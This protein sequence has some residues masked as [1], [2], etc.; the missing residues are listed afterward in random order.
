MSDFF[1]QGVLHPLVMPAHL[2]LLIALGLL[3]GQQSGRAV[4]AS[5]VILLLSLI[6]A[7]MATLQLRLRL[8]LEIALLLSAMIAGGLVALRLKLPIW[9]VLLLALVAGALV[10]LDSS[11]P[12]I[13]GLR[14]NKVHVLLA[15]TTLSAVSVSL[16]CG[17]FALMV[18]NLLEGIVLRVLGAWITAGALLVLALY[19]VRGNLI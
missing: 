10:G 1:L 8:E 3:A 14:G 12:R 2:I 5:C 9:P 11:A 16:I 15:G 4:R 19:V 13:P 17:L 18:R 6:A 7:C